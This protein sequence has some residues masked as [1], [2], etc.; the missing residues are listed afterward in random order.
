[1]NHTCSWTGVARGRRPGPVAPCPSPTTGNTLG[2]ELNAHLCLVMIGTVP[3]FLMRNQQLFQQE[4]Q[5]KTKHLL[6]TMSI[7]KICRYTWLIRSCFPHCGIASLAQVST[8]GLC[9]LHYD[10]S[11]TSIETAHTHTHNNGDLSTSQKKIQSSPHHLPSRRGC[12]NHQ[13]YQG[14]GGQMEPGSWLSQW[15]VEPKIGG[16]ENP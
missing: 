11:F 14:L 16:F 4:N 12:P 2:Q 6:I 15:G 5:R 8:M 9:P 7:P 3:F 13:E 1:M 10:T